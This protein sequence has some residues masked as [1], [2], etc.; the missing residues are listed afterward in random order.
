MGATGQVGSRQ[1]LG[2][3]LA[4]TQ[5]PGSPAFFPLPVFVPLC[6]AASFQKVP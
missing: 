6:S 5:G 1:S 2:P 3:T 4:G